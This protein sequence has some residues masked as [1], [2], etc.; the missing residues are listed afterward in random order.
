MILANHT[1]TVFRNILDDEGR[2]IAHNAVIERTIT[3]KLIGMHGVIAGEKISVMP[4]GNVVNGTVF[5]TSYK[6]NTYCIYQLSQIPIDAHLQPISTGDGRE[7]LF[8]HVT[9]NV[10][11]PRARFMANT[12]RFEFF[13][14]LGNPSVNAASYMIIR[15]IATRRLHAVGL[16]NTWDTDARACLGDKLV[17]NLAKNGVMDINGNYKIWYDSQYNNHLREEDSNTMRYFWKFDTDQEWKPDIKYA[18]PVYEG[19]WAGL[20]SQLPSLR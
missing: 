9:R 20:L 8:Y 2:I 17:Q 12:T 18:P 13:V 14:I 3:E 7:K 16:P 4:V 1:E 6:N 11:Q 15:D 10:N 5:L 19:I